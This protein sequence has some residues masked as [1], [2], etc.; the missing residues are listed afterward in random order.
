MVLR[1]RE[2][3]RAAHINQTQLASAMGVTQGV[4][5][6]WETEIILPR[7]R[8][9]PRLASALGCSIGDL[10]AESEDEPA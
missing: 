7:T 2:L 10:F 3:R 8:D 9:L 6:N 1:I 4:V 5:S